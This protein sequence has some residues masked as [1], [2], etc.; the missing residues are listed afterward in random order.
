[1]LVTP[2]AAV[3]RRDLDALQREIEAYADERELWVTAPGIANP[4][5][6]LALHLAG[7]LRHFVGAV[8]GGDGYRRDRE[9]EF[10][11]RGVSRQEV[12]AEIG[13]AREVVESVLARVP[14]GDMEAPFP[15]EIAG[16]RL[17]TAQ[18]LI[19]LACHLA[20]HL[21]QVNYHRRLLASAAPAATDRAE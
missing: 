2:I 12:L 17:S 1:M 5:G 15:A 8:L 21:G 9:A 16:E 20:Y 14:E 6:T 3:I 11:R 10:A 7:N 13:R 4:A 19:H 18:A